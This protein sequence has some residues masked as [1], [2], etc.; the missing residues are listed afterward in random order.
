MELIIL[1]RC[2]RVT[3]VRDGELMICKYCGGRLKFRY[4]EERKGCYKFEGSN[5]YGV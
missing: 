4:V 5:P 1:C 3:V 2:G